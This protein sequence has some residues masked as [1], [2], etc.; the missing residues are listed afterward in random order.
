MKAPGDTKPGRGGIQATQEAA[1]KT[2]EKDSQKQ[3]KVPHLPLVDLHN[4]YHRQASSKKYRNSSAGYRAAARKRISVWFC[5]QGNHTDAPIQPSDDTSYRKTAAL[6]HPGDAATRRPAPLF[7]NPASP[8]P[9]PRPR[10]R[11]RRNGYRIRQRACRTPF[12]DPCGNA[13]ADLSP[14]CRQWPPAALC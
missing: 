4:A 7:T 11:A 1:W 8:L 14:V 12:R 2:S 6:S 3:K 13:A 5:L 9:E 10:H